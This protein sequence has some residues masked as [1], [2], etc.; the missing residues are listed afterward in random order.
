MRV[1]QVKG[2]SARDQHQIDA[3]AAFTLLKQFLIPPGT[4]AIEPRPKD[5]Y[6]LQR[7][8]GQV[9]LQTRVLPLAQNDRLTRFGF[10][11][12]ECQ[13]SGQNATIFPCGQ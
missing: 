8:L 5:R 4:R 11:N 6:D 1:A 2:D 10:A 3:T 7:V 13:F 12:G 9:F